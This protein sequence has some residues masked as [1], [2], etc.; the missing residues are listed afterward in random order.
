MGG[1]STSVRSVVAGGSREAGCK[2]MRVVRRVACVC[3]SINLFWCR[4]LTRY[5]YE[6][7]DRWVW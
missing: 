7:L 1:S 5:E 2:L 3:V 4:S 6:T